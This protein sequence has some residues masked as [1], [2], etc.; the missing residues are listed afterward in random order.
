MYYRK[1][2]SISRKK[3]PYRYS[4]FEKKIAFSK[5]VKKKIKIKT[6]ARRKKMIFTNH[7]YIY[8]NHMVLQK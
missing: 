6:P 2:K 7:R 4:K 3:K 1:K 8:N 5:K